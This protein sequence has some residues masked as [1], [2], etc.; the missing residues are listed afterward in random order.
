MQQAK[1]IQIPAIPANVNI[2]GAA[3]V[4][5][6]SSTGNQNRIIQALAF[7]NPDVDPLITL[8]NPC[9]NPWDKII[10]HLNVF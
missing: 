1:Q 4:L 7:R 10:Q 6:L 9:S 3:A 5:W 2:L 8:A